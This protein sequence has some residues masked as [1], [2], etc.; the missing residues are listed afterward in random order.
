MSRRNSISSE[1]GIDAEGEAPVPSRDLQPEVYESLPAAAMHPTVQKAIEQRARVF[2]W[3]RRYQ[4]SSRAK[5]RNVKIKIL[6]LAQEKARPLRHRAASRP[7]PI[8]KRY[9][10]KPSLDLMRVLDYVFGAYTPDRTGKLK[11]EKFFDAIGQFAFDTQ[12]VSRQLNIPIRTLQRI[13]AKLAAMRLIDC[14]QT[15]RLDQRGEYAG[16]KTWITARADLYLGLMNEISSQK[17]GG[18]APDNRSQTPPV[19]ASPASQNEPEKAE[20]L[21]PNRNDN[22]DICY[23]NIMETP[24]HVPAERELPVS[25]YA[26]VFSGAGAPLALPPKK[27]FSKGKNIPPV[28]V[29]DPSLT[30]SAGP[31]ADEHPASSSLATNQHSEL[32][33]EASNSLDNLNPQTPVPSLAEPFD[34]LDVGCKV[35]QRFARRVQ[36][37]FTGTDLTLAQCQQLRSWTIRA[38]QRERMTFEDLDEILSEFQANR[39]G[40][41]DSHGKFYKL[42]VE[43]LLARWPQFLLVYQQKRLACLDVNAIDHILEMAT[44]RAEAEFEAQVQHEIKILLD[45][46]PYDACSRQP[47]ELM[48]FAIV[49]FHRL[50]MTPLIDE[51]VKDHQKAAAMVEGMR[52]DPL[53]AL[54]ARQKYPTVFGLFAFPPWFWNQLRDDVRRG[55]QHLLE[56]KTEAEVWGVQEQISYPTFSNDNHNPQQS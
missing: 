4:F 36:D 26:D 30:S 32:A 21:E 27:K 38:S 42:T 11:Y 18:Q 17:P 25:S 50:S 6:S 16:S 56:L 49:A 52:R 1:Y 22:I 37:A 35:F 46:L 34:A 40:I 43:Q 54:M 29:S 15:P 28:V 55:Y 14:T 19:E 45:G 5:D 44:T 24:S 3:V 41:Q 12:K 13:V 51:I 20:G 8:Q 31:S 2:A 47:R 7:E 23:Y 10:V 53:S 9:R 39:I 33:H 48:I